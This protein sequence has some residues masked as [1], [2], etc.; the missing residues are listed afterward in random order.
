MPRRSRAR[1]PSG[2]S[3]QDP[4]GGIQADFNAEMEPTY[5]GGQ[6][7]AELDT[8]T[9]SGSDAVDWFILDPSCPARTLPASLTHQGVVAV[10]D[11]SLLYPYTAVDSSGV[12]YL[13]FSLSGPHNYPSPAYIAYNSSGPTGPVI[14]ATPGPLPRTASPV[15]PPSSAP[16]TAAAVGVTTRWGSSWATGSSWRPRWFPRDSATPSPT[17]APTSGAHRRHRPTPDQRDDVA[18]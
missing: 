17:G 10:A 8:A 4:A 5:V 6:I 7:Y 3:Y 18:R 9:K 1:G 2:K 11:T 16:T 15:T 12:G 14:V 13:L